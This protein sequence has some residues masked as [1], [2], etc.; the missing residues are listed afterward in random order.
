LASSAVLWAINARQG[1]RVSSFVCVQVKELFGK[2]FYA[3]SIDVDETIA[4]CGKA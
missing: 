4:G 3:V 2:A 1:I